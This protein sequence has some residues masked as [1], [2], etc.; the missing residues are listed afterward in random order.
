MGVSTDM[1]LE[2]ILLYKLSL[3]LFVFTVRRHG[4]YNVYINFLSG[5]DFKNDREDVKDYVQPG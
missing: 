3:F 1:N 2:L 5:L 4:N